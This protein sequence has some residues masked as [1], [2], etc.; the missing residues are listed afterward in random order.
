MNA[1][2]V[3]AT[4]AD[5][6]TQ[7]RRVVTGKAQWVTDLI[8][9]LDSIS[10]KQICPYGKPGDRL[11]V[12]ESFFLDSEVD[13]LFCADSS[14]D[15][16]QIVPED[17]EYRGLSEGVTVPSIHAPRWASR[18][19]LEITDIRVERVRN[20]TVQDATCEGIVDCEMPTHALESSSHH[21]V[22]VLSKFQLLWDS[23]NA[24]RKDKK[25]NLLPYAWADNPFVWVVEFRRI[26]S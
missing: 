20:I 18:T 3:R 25:G 22:R 10:P 17:Y 1:E 14:Y 9:N 4:L 5:R 12:R 6:K 13:I 11:W 8:H 24:K 7:T 16:K 15:L 19:T 2:M 21:R 23:I 26:K